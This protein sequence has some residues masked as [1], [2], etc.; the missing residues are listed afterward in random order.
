MKQIN[1]LEWSKHYVQARDAIERKLKTI[2][3]KPDR[4]IC[5]YK[6]KQV[7]FIA[8]ETLTAKSLDANAFTTIVTLQTTKNFD[9]LIDQFAVFSQHPKLT[10]IFVNPKL[11]EKWM[12]KP[13]VHAAV[14]D[15]STLK[16][17]LQSM[18][19]TVPSV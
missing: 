18:F 3:E 19:D 2:D 15:K 4:L 9:A 13:A 6:D 7:T 10:I 14:A 8:E 1:L 5:T 12:I 11:N 16:L 17:G